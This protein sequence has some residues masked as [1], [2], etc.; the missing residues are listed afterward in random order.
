M[1]N[2]VVPVCGR[3]SQQL[4]GEERVIFVSFVKFGS[5][6]WY[7]RVQNRGRA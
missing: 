4:N 3:R 7:G 1:V 5:G 2:G 6:S